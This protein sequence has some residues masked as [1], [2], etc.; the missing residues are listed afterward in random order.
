[1]SHNLI[2]GSDTYNTISTSTL[3]PIQKFKTSERDM[4]SQRMV[5]ITK[6]P[7]DND[8]WRWNLDSYSGIYQT[9][10]MK[11]ECCIVSDNWRN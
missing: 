3:L 4:K 1:M 6:I 10:F 9:S 7:G 2:L 5:H 8:N 11:Y